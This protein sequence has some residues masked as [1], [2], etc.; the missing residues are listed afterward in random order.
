MSNAFVQQDAVQHLL[1]ESAG[2]NA[3]GG[4]FRFKAIVHCLLENIVTL[5]VY[6]NVSE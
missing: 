3:T 2:L 4:D 1:R 6:Y 5:I